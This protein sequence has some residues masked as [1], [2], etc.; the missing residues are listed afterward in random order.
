MTY[1]T[2][3]FGPRNLLGYST[4]AVPRDGTVQRSQAG[5]VAPGQSARTLTGRYALSQTGTVTVPLLS[6]PGTKLFLITDIS[7]TWDTAQVAE[8]T[9]QAGGISLWR[10][11]VKGDTAPCQFPGIE[12]QVPVMPGQTLSLVFGQV[13]AA[14]NADFVVSG[15]QQNVGVG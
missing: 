11:I 3:G 12:T 2:G 7:V 5:F 8:V 9:L 10:V 13:G 4:E 6:V 15:V 14:T 1:N